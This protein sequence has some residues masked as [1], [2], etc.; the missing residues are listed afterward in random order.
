MDDNATDSD[1]ASQL[2]TVNTRDG[3]IDFAVYL[4]EQL[5]DLQ[6][7]FDVRQCATG[8]VESSVGI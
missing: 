3:L 4:I 6:Y 2:S 1:E 5:R 8:A 7:S